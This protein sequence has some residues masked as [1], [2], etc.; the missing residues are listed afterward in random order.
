MS[1][2]R[3]LP[4][5]SVQQTDRLQAR[6]R[7]LQRLRAEAPGGRLEALPLVRGQATGTRAPGPKELRWRS[8]Q[9]AVYPP[10]IRIIGHVVL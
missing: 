7:Q 10:K 6:R 4:P 3:D 5:L 8:E 2:L 1:V 9:V